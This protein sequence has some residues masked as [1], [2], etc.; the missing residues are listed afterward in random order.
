MEERTLIILKPDTVQ[1]A[2]SGK[3]LARF[4]DAGFKIIAMKML[5]ADPD[6]AKNHY[7]VDEAWAQSVFE[8]TKKA[9][10]E[11]GEELEYDSPMDLAK[12]IQSWNMN[13]LQEGPVIAAVL[14]APHAVEL[15]RKLVGT[16]EPKQSPPGTIRGDY[17]SIESYKVAD[18]NK[19]VLR[20][21]IHASD[22]PENAEREISLW[23]T[24][25]EILE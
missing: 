24:E 25:K 1:R 5:Q 6:L 9:K 20:N 15:A 2:L 10:E 13:F 23:F 16:T 19:R 3:I 14:K 22:S 12:T 18:T 21:L 8:K 11:S 7:R 4:E 17:A